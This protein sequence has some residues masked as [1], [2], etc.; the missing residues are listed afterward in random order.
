MQYAAKTTPV[1]EK[2]TILDVFVKPVYFC[3]DFTIKSR[4]ELRLSEGG[5]NEVLHEDFEA[6]LDL[7]SAITMLLQGAIL[8]PEL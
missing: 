4:F 3:S 7:D 8:E 5:N 1:R 6:S 2:R